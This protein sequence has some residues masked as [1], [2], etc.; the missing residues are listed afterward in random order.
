MGAL[1]A[2]LKFTRNVSSASLTVSPLTTTVI[3]LE[4]CPAAEGS[5]AELARESPGALAVPFAVAQSTETGKALA[6]ERLTVRT[7]LVVAV[8]PSDNVTLLLVRCGRASSFV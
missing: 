2:L 5:V 1:R 8:L 7:A 3:V 6:A 4:V